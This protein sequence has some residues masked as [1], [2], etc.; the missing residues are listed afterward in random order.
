MS[1]EVNRQRRFFLGSAGAGIAAAEMAFM[2]GAHAQ[3]AAPP[4]VSAS[5]TVQRLEPI[6]QIKAGE[7]DVGYYEAGPADGIPV[8]LLHGY[9]YDIHS[10]ADAV[11]KLA[12]ATR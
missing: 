6:K 5:G 8:L 1:E 10:Y 9:P 7:L 2:G 3:S 4:S 12:S 11:W